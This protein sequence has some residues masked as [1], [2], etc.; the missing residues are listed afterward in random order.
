M[1]LNALNLSFRTNDCSKLKNP[2]LKANAIIIT[3]EIRKEE[4]ILTLIL[5]FLNAKT[6]SVDIHNKTRRCFTNAGA[7]GVPMHASANILTE[8]K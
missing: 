4:V 8:E 6:A 7:F 5:L 3:L 2:L 1:R